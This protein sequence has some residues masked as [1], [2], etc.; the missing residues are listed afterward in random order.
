MINRFLLFILLITT[1]ATTRSQNLP[2]G[3]WRDC[4]P[5]RYGTGVVKGNG[6]IYCITS[7]AIFS[8]N[9]SDNSIQKYN[10]VTGL[11]DIGISTA[12]Y[13][14]VYHVLVI[15]YA[16]SNVDLLYDNGQVV[17]LPFIEQASIIENKTIN[18][19]YFIGQDAYICCNFG[20][21]NLNLSTQ[22]I[23]NTPPYIIG[24][25][26]DAINVF[27]VSLLNDTVYAATTDGVCYAPLID[28][29]SF[30]FYST[31]T[32]INPTSGLPAVKTQFVQSFNNKMYA[33]QNGTTNASVYI[34]NSINNWSP[35]YTG[36]NWT[37]NGVSAS[38][39]N[40]VLAQDYGN[41]TAAKINLINAQGVSTS[42]DSTGL[43]KPIQALQV[44]GSLW[45]ADNYNGLYHYY[46]NGYNENLT[47]NGPSTAGDNSIAAYNGTMYVAPSNLS[48]PFNSDG[49][50]VYSNNT[51]NNYNQYTPGFSVLSTI[52]E[53]NSVI[54]S[55]VDYSAYFGTYNGLIHFAN[56]A[57]QTIYN[58]S[59]STLT[60]QNGNIQSAVVVSGM[61][62][63]N[64]NNLW[65]SNFGAEPSPIS[66]LENPSNGG[67]WEAFSPPSFN[68]NFYTAMVIDQFNQQWIMNTLGGILVMNN[69][70]SLTPSSADLYK[71][72][73]TGVGNGNLPSGQVTSLVVDQLGNVWVGTNEGITVFYCPGDVLTSTGCDAQ[74]IIYSTP[75]GNGYLLGTDVINAIVVDGANRKW[76]GTNTGLYLLSADGTSQI[77]NFTAQNSPLFSNDIIS[78]ALDPVNGDLFIGTSAGILEYRTTANE[79]S[80]TNCN[81]TVFPD[82]VR[83]NYFGPITIAG[84]VANATVKITDVNGDL[85][86]ETTALGGQAIWNGNMQNGARAKTGVYLV[87][88]S[89][90]DGSVHCTG[91][92]LLIN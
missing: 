46:V 37:I 35:V 27:S 3:G 11:S 38:S 28:T 86:Y 80:Q 21:V 14:T 82:P 73:S 71:A 8:V 61:A 39:A 24:P 13:D 15:G 90:S 23:N 52:T 55:P 63:D 9:T 18:S 42:V 54:I 70:G 58:A 62:Y 76:V 66:V 44:N 12:A 19:I 26:G 1:F 20:I 65:V 41:V 50:F 48:S 87:F 64:E 4:L 30:Q 45:I 43:G 32:Y 25:G 77:E 33:I 57:I 88:V 81:V 6:K 72:L 16:N 56:G 17:N 22:L 69:N 91:K 67:T 34:K 59:N 36:T 89:N 74:Q 79:G 60:H 78:L 84:V 49:F 85:V 2:I 10:K 75:S 7:L 29:P 5:Y 51:W 47:P 53:I 31:W 92:F 40:L 68:E 83:Q